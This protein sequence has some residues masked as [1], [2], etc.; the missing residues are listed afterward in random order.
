MGPGGGSPPSGTSSSDPGQAGLPHSLPPLGTG[1]LV[2]LPMGTQVSAG[3]RRRSSA[4]FN[5]DV[6]IN[7]TCKRELTY[8]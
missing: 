5:I 1:S 2:S 7:V 3:M 8:L 6:H 4:T